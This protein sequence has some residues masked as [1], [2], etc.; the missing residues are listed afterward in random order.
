MA[1]KKKRK[2]PKTIGEMTNSR[3]EWLMNPLTRVKESQKG[4]NR[5]KDKDKIRKGDY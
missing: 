1:K 2:K 4:Y 5:K 3:G